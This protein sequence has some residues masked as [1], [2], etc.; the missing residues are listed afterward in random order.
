MQA[1]PVTVDICQFFAEARLGRDADALSLQPVAEGSDQGRR[2]G[3][4]CRETLA[5][6]CASDVIFDS[7]DFG[8]L[9]QAFG[10]DLG[11]VAVVD[12][13]ELAAGVMAWMPPLAQP[14]TVGAG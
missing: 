7:I 14:A 12:F 2:S 6:G 13:L 10:G 1:V 9:A 11:L 5:G 8:D 3:L 4:A